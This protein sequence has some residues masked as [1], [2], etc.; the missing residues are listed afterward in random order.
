MSEQDQ[1]TATQKLSPQS[2]SGDPN[3]RRVLVLRDPP[4]RGWKLE[5]LS[6]LLSSPSPLPLQGGAD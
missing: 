3:T 5:T 2:E 6:S 4:E 1:D